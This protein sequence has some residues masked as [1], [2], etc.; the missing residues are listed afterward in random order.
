M[1]YD[2]TDTDKIISEQGNAGDAITIPYQRNNIR[3]T[4]AL[5]Y[6]RQADV[7]YQFKLEGYSKHWSD[8]SGASQKDFTNLGWGKYRFLIKART[9]GQVQSK[10]SLKCFHHF[11]PLNLPMF[12]TFSF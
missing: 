6:Y 4:Y 5:P 7:K 10:M 3:I 11:T 8:W 2:L 12:F 9:S 1:V